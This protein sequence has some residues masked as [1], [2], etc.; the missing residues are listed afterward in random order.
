MA[1]TVES[2]T[3]RAH[4]QNWT[5][6]GG[7][8]KSELGTGQDIHN[9]LEDPFGSVTSAGVT[10]LAQGWYLASG[11]QTTNQPILTPSSAP[12]PGFTQ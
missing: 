10:E 2:E 7:E 4:L 8:G 5:A 12:S 1:G 6:Q 9:I 11:D 3:H